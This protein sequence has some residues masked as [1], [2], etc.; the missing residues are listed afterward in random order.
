MLAAG[1]IDGAFMMLNN[2]ECHS[3]SES[4]AVSLQCIIRLAEFLKFVVGHADSVIR[5]LNENH[6]FLFLNGDLDSAV[7]RRHSFNTV[8]NQINEGLFQF[9]LCPRTHIN[10]ARFER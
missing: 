7:F 8:F 4:G 1:E 2:R 3:K 5:N 9:F 6:L 10:P